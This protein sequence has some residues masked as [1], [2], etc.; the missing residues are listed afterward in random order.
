MD[1]TEEKYIGTIQSTD[2]ESKSAE[3]NSVQDFESCTIEAVH[4]ESVTG[5][6]DETHQEYEAIQTTAV[7]PEAEVKQSSAFKSETENIVEDI[8]E[9]GICH[10]KLPRPYYLYERGIGAYGFSQQGKSHID[11]NVRCQ[12]RFGLR[13]IAE[14]GMTV[15]A[16]ADGVGSCQLSDLGADCAVN[17][18]L[19]YLEEGIRTLKGKVGKDSALN[20]LRGALKEAYQKVEKLADEQQILLYTFQSTLTLALYDGNILYYGHAGDDG[21]VAVFDD[22]TYRMVTKRHKGEEASSVYPLQSIPTWETG[23]VKN[24]VAFTLCTDGVLDGFVGND[25]ENNRVYFPFIE[26]DVLAEISCIDDIRSLA[27]LRFDFMLTDSYRNRVTDDLTIITVINAPAVKK[28]KKKPEFDLVKW[29]DDTARYAER[30]KQILYGNQAPRTQTK[31]GTNTAPPPVSSGTY[32]SGP[33]SGPNANNTLRPSGYSAGQNV[34]GQG[35]G[36]LAQPATGRN[37]NSVYS[38]VRNPAPPASYAVNSENKAT[39]KAE[40]FVKVL[41]IALIPGLLGTIFYMTLHMKKP[42]Q[43][44]AESVRKLIS[45]CQICVQNELQLRNCG[46]LLIDDETQSDLCKRNEARRIDN[47]S[48][49]NCYEDKD[50]ER[51]L[52]F[53]YKTDLRV[54]K[55]NSLL[56][57][58]TEEENLYGI[59]KVSKIS[60]NSRGILKEGY[61]IELPNNLGDCQVVYSDKN[62]LL[63]DYFKQDMPVE[64]ELEGFEADTDELTRKVEEPVEAG[65]TAGTGSLGGKSKEQKAD[66]SQNRYETSHTGT[67]SSTETGFGTELSVTSGTGEMS[68]LESVDEDEYDSE[69]EYGSKEAEE[70]SGISH[71]SEAEQSSEYGELEYD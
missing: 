5:N 20:L 53:V 13:S 27:K 14:Y 67:E 52:Y 29:N 4:S 8:D 50:N 63:N 7:N 69:N 46:I 44:K 17:S 35:T 64:R 18:S 12:D 28:M 19:N 71:A 47:L 36:R 32:Y 6:T 25:V 9:N 16:V 37:S 62:K 2:N 70:E 45:D 65:M 23:A 51:V 39:L 31:S 60:V 30:R 34:T 41:L 26:K 22:G 68:A 59:I 48:I 33:K 3:I 58:E 49:R 1:N 43:M 57:H 66:I 15:A 55:K 10:P 40:R 24:V 54:L 61:Q 42:Y 38:S 11:K 21:I 56:I